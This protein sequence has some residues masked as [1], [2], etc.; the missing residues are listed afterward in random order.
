MTDTSA[1]GPKELIDVHSNMHPPLNGNQGCSS[2]LYI[3]TLQ[4]LC[5]VCTCGVSWYFSY[6]L[7][8]H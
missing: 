4:K 1:I 3:I 2:D 8:K 6:V 5:L 7:K